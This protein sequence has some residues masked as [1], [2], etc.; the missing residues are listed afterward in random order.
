[1]NEKRTSERHPFRWYVPPNAHTL[2]IGT[3][4]PGPHRW[5]YPFFYPNKRN[6][7]WKIMSAIDGTPLSEQ[8]EDPVNDRRQI[9]DRLGVG[10]TDMAMEIE[11]LQNNAADE[12]L[13]IIEYMPVLDILR[14]NPTIRKI[15]LTS[16]SGAA[17][18]LKWFM[19]YL[20]EHHI[21][22]SAVQRKKPFNFSIA[23]D[24]RPIIVHVLY[25]PSPRASNR[26][27]PEKLTQMYREVV[28][29]LKG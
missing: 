3:F 27:S 29:E 10:I 20:V 28:R 8:S 24:G 13:R 17:S 18:A 16:S 14:D 7:F 23:I 6:S 19:A 2:V 22:H 12:N 25:S 26:I 5:A 21:S 15:I 4:P 1:M 11:R 9:L